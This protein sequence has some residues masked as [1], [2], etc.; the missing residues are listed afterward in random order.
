MARWLSSLRLRRAILWGLVCAAGMEIVTGSLLAAPAELLDRVVAEVN[1]EVILW[2]QL[3]EAEERAGGPSDSRSVRALERAEILE[4]MIDAALL[5]QEGERM[6]LEPPAEQIAEAVD[7]RVDE[8]EAGWPST[9]TFN[10]ALAAMGETRATLR[11]RLRREETEAWLRRAVVMARMGPPPADLELTPQFDLAQIVLSCRPDAPESLALQLHRECL[12]LRERAIEG[13]D[14]A[15]LALHHSE[16]TVTAQRGG[17]IGVVD[18]SLLDPGIAEALEG[19]SDGDITLPIRTEQGWHLLLVKR[20]ITPRQQWQ[21]AEF[22]RA[23][24]EI[25]DDLRRRSHIR[26]HLNE[27]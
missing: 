2:S 25:V 1:D 17:D 7:E 22:E 3:I 8:I 9:H 23:R 12:E 4:T 11:Q 27:E 10:E 19:L 13:E 24:R 15:L 18:P 14:F 5:R 20:V 16:D 26:V 21:M 6:G